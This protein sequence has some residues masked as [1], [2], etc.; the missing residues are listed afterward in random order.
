MVQNAMTSNA[1]QTIF[2]ED[3]AKWGPDKPPSAC[4]LPF[5]L[6]YCRRI[7][8]SH[9]ENFTVV[10]LFLPRA[11]RQDF[12]NFYAYCRWSDDIADEVAEHLRLP[13]LGWWQQQLAL[14]YSGRPAH[15]VMLALQHT[16]QRHQIPSSTLE[17]LLSAFRQDQSRLRYQDESEL[18]E[19][20]RRSANPVGR[21]I[22]KFAKADD[23]H[24]V[25]LSD[26]ICSGLQLANFCQDMSRDAANNRIYAPRELCAKHAVTESMVL[27]A[28]CTPQLQAMLAEWVHHSRE[29]FV[30]G[31]SLVDSVPKWLAVDVD[32][33]IRGGLAILDAIEAQNFDVW[34]SRPTLSKFAKFRLLWKALVNRFQRK[35]HHG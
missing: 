32:L 31:S 19:Y 20:C 21:V 2:W 30:R 13:L 26:W 29:L 24:N 11:L 3:L 10:S 35:S 1:A 16:I 25:E 22:L 15:P 4:D 28:K 5:A 12:Y 23:A 33:F 34:T 6:T 18:L 8:R 17:D 14:C 7:A 27:D 9:Y